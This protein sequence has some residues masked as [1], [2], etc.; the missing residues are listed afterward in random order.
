MCA[1][2]GSLVRIDPNA[3]ISVINAGIEV[4]RRHFPHETNA[5]LVAQ[6]NLAASYLGIGRNDKALRLYR[7]VF[8]TRRDIYGEESENT[9]VNGN[10]LSVILMNNAHY[11]EAKTF[12]RR[13]AAVAR[14]AL[15]ENSGV[16]IG[17]INL[18]AEALMRDPSASRSDF[19]EAE[20]LLAEIAPKSRHVCGPHHPRALNYARNLVCARQILARLS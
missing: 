15:P 11:A 5:L 1:L 16:G 17:A 18:L 20:A 3:A 12:A 7:S 6:A 2:G 8:V 14:R 10:N 4:L 19:L 13:Q 9:I